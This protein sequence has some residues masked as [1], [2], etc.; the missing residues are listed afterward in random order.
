M[1]YLDYKSHKLFF[2]EKGKGPLLIIL[3]GNTSSSVW[4]QG[5][6]EYF[7]SKYQVAVLDFLG[8]GRSDRLNMWYDDWWYEGACQAKALVEHLNKNK[9]I[10]MGT[11][12]GAVS[13][14]LMAI[15]FPQYVSSVIA[16]SCIEL[17]SPQ[18]LQNAVKDRNQYT[19]EQITFW[20]KA[21][22]DDWEQVVNA[23][24]SMLLRMASRGGY[25]F[26]GRL[27]EI[28]CPVLFTASLR[29][30]FLPDISRQVCDMGKQVSE[31]RIYFCNSGDHP[32]M[33]SQSNDFRYISNWFMESVSQNCSVPKLI[34]KN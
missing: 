26:K 28:Q 12:G 31:S 16:D 33:W 7:S 8:T 23:D 18:L 3:P 10:V 6:L 1:A 15:H 34:Q 13:A 21:H 27:K 11:S 5:E 9:C 20:E 25:C 4:H 24:N 19:A 14:L 32:L 17:F 2:C 22:G 29:D 30:S